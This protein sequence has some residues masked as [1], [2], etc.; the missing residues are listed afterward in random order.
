MSLAPTD[1]R[2]VLPAPVQSENYAR[3]AFIRAMGAAATSVTIVSTDGPAGRCAQT[4]SAM[5]S[6]SAD[7]PCLL[8]CVN[9]KSPLA[10]AVL[11]NGTL[12]VNVLA[13]GQ[14]DAAQT[15]A[16]QSV[17][18]GAPYD[19]ARHQW[20]AG[21]L[22]QPQLAGSSAVF[23]CRLVGAHRY[24]THHVFIASPAESVPGAPDAQPMTYHAR[25]FGT[26]SPRA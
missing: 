22:G 25:R 21:A 7:P 26:H 4:V 19:F 17:D 23:E 14:A 1:P 20:Q 11:A 10:A 5:A 3:E 15:F 2:P 18:G 24:G 12:A 9:D 8:V 13:D 16:G 6:V